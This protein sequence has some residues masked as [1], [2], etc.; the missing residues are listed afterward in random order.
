MKRRT[1]VRHTVKSHTREGKRVRSFERGR[2]TKQKQRKTVKSKVV[3]SEKMRPIPPEQRVNTLAEELQRAREKDAPMKLCYHGAYTREVAEQILK[4]G[5]KDGT[6]FTPQMENAYAAGARPYVF[7]V[8][9]CMD[10]KPR[11]GWQWVET[12]ITST[13]RIHALYEFD[14]D[15][16][17]K[18]QHV[19]DVLSEHNMD[20]MRRKGK[21]AV[22]G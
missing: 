1:P 19:F 4:E 3:G 9:F 10:F 17:Y 16:L 6:Y 8:L 2:G 5:F 14:K 15:P 20:L 22:L 13:D 11:G 12:G 18:N 7:E 21:E